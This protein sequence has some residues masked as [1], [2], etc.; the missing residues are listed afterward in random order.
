VAT[1]RD[2]LSK[3]GER[4]W[5]GPIRA[6]R[7]SAAHGVEYICRAWIAA[8]AAREAAVILATGFIIYHGFIPSEGSDTLIAMA[9]G[10]PLVLFVAA[11]DQAGH[12]D[13]P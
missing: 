13:L 9:I 1:Q 6:N 11:G 4:H 8:L 3:R 2:D 10:Q 7:A 12:S 5:I